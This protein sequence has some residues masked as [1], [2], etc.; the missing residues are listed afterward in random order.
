MHATSHYD[1]WLPSVGPA[2]F[3]DGQLVK[4]QTAETSAKFL[5]SVE[6]ALGLELV[7]N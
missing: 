7:T 6:D 3:A 1:H 5:P 4:G 2:V